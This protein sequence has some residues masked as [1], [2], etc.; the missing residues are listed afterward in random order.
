MSID[1]RVAL[2]DLVACPGCDLLHR[3]ARLALGEQARCRRCRS[4]LLTRKPRTVERTLA[5]CLGGIVFLL[6]S[7]TL[8]FLALSR[9]GIESRISVLDAV[10]SL[11]TSDLR[12]L[13]LLTLALIVVFPLARLVLL[14]W[15]MIG[16]RASGLPDDARTAGRGS[17]RHGTL[18]RRAFRWAIRL[19][20]WAMADVFM[21]GVAISLVKLG[22]VARLEV[23]LAF[24][25][26]CALIVTTVLVERVLCKDT[27]WRY[28]D[29]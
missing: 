27:V 17:P 14:A 5:L 3:R 11:W 26:L 18:R 4:V 28:L 24:W 23:G 15:V 6:L 21:I 2:D 10:R 9:S 29:S 25:A 22:S 1:P 8:P 20:P 7:L 16:V 12:W 19:E 13:G